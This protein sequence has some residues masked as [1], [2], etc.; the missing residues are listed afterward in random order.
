MSHLRQQIREKIESLLNGGALVDDRVYKNRLHSLEGTD[1]PCLDIETINDV[2]Q[3]QVEFG[4]P[5]IIGREL[6]VAINVY[7][8]KSKN[9]DDELDA[10]CTEV[11][12]NLA[13]N[14]TLDGLATRA[15]QVSTQM[16]F[17]DEGDKPHGLARIEYTV[18]Y[19]T[20][21]AD[22]TGPA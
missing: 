16:E 20:Q 2:S 1:L 3:G 12:T 9:I 19:R 14:P 13:N 21:E 8:K 18:V 6:A 4:T 22:P 7:V 17:T 5:I 11:E 15:T 10:I